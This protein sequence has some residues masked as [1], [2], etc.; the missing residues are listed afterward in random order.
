MFK[1][2]GYHIPLDTLSNLDRKNAACSKLN[3]PNMS[4]K[5]VVLWFNSKSFSFRPI[6]D[7]LQPRTLQHGFGRPESEKTKELQANRLQPSGLPW[8]D[9]GRADV[10]WRAGFGE[11]GRGSISG[12]TLFQSFSKEGIAQIFPVFWLP[13]LLWQ[14]PGCIWRKVLGESRSR[15]RPDQFLLPKKCTPVICLLLLDTWLLNIFQNRIQIVEKV[16]PA[17][18]LSLVCSDVQQEFSGRRSWLW[19]LANDAPS[20]CSHS[21]WKRSILECVAVEGIQEDL[22]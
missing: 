18:L 2:V 6:S 10:K 12:E 14:T 4:S 11:G 22:C 8:G 20:P 5:F 17:L 9:L 13:V 1:I 19:R 16:S 21:H 7:R 15:D 3:I